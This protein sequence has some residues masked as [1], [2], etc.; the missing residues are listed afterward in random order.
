MNKKHLENAFDQLSDKHIREAAGYKRPRLLPY[1]GAIAACL[2]CAILLSTFAPKGSNVAIPTDPILSTQAPDNYTPPKNFEGTLTPV[3]IHQST[4]SA[5]LSA[6][7]YPLMAPY[8]T[9]TGYSAWW[10]SLRQIHY[11]DLNYASNLDDYF[12]KI[13]PAVLNDQEGNSVFSPL[14]IYMALSML[15]ETTEGTSRQQILNLLNAEDVDALRHQAEQLWRA[16]Y[17]NDGL[18][19]SILGS[20]LWLDNSYAYNEETVQTLAKYYYASVFRGKMGSAE[21]N[22][23]L[24]QWLNDNTGSL[25]KDQVADVRL[26]EE[27][28]LALAT[29]IY[30]Q[31]QWQDA[32]TGG[33]TGIF[34]GPSADQ[35]IEFLYDYD[36]YGQYYW[37]EDF[38][39]A[40]LQLRDGSTMW[41]ILPD[42]GK[43]PHDL[44]AS[45]KAL[46]MVL[47]DNYSQSKRMQVSI[48]VPKF[49][50]TSDLSVKNALQELGITS[51]FNKNADFSPIL[52]EEK[53]A[54]VDNVKHATRLIMNE[55]GISAAAYT[56]IMLAGAAEPP[57]DRIDLVFDRPFLFVVESKDG[58]PLFVGTVYEP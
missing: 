53:G 24:Q 37:G 3:T 23:A 54:Y 5:L 19:T 11:T 27:M 36:L 30:Y 13:C 50:V 34:H 55:D 45:G 48:T 16:H 52:P 42:E 33:N 56:V 20:S 10:E 44:L 28:A 1:M 40:C 32:L 41:L 2:V 49:D 57:T 14:N 12:K 18:A 43:T 25:L 31:V 35:K 15:A 7:V 39:A 8:A 9:G 46:D 4:S 17:Y 29:T 58:L 38:G 21:L 22:S 6:P 26:Q 47:S 51:V